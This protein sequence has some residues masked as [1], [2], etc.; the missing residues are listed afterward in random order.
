MMET[1]RVSD[2]SK[3][4]K[5]RRQSLIT[6]SRNFTIKGVGELGLEL[7]MAG[8]QSKE[9]SDSSLTLFSGR[10]NESISSG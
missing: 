3:S 4:D 2:L 5:H 1:V 8:R 7:D 10:Q 9:P 6:F